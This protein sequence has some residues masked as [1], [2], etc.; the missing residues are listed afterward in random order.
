MAETSP[1]TF[2]PYLQNSCS[3]SPPAFLLHSQYA[4]VC[5][6]FLPAVESTTFRNIRLTSADLPRVPAIFAP[7]R[8]L[9]ALQRIEFGGHEGTA[10]REVQ[11][12]LGELASWG[13]EKA[14]ITLAIH[15]INALSRAQIKAD[16]R[17]AELQLPVVTFVAASATSGRNTSSRSKH[18]PQAAISTIDSLSY[19][20][21]NLTARCPCLKHFA[22]AGR[23]L[24]SPNLFRLAH[25]CKSSDDNG[26]ESPI[27]PC[28]EQY[29]GCMDAMTPGGECYYLPSLTGA[30]CIR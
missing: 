9:R 22:L 11:Q 20:L 19:A 15:P 24:V 17:W 13:A 30:S 28:M 12:L 5:G 29:H 7:T 25:E 26:A 1:A 18:I 3:K 14:G 8:R 23:A 10:S 27:W 2:H 21:R 16:H 4:T 6:A